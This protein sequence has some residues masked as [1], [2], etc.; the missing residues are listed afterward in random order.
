MDVIPRL[1]NCYTA[2][3]LVLAS[4]PDPLQPSR[5]GTKHTHTQ[6]CVRACLM[7]HTESLTYLTTM[8]GHF[9]NLLRSAYGPPVC[10][11]VVIR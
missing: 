11:Y 10:A 6:A 4:R 8:A 1:P 3:R 2:Q 5:N 7:A 9:R